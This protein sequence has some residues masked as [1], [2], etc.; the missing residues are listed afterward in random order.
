MPNNLVAALIVKN[1]EPVL[2]RC[3]TSLV[4]DVKRFVINDNGSTD[5]T[6]GILEE[7]DAVQVPGPWIDYA[8][9]RNLVLNV[10]KQWGD[11][12]F[13]GIDAD[14]IFHTPEGWVWPELTADG[15]FIELRL[16]D[17]RYQ[18]L[19]IVKSTSGLA[20][21]GVIHEAIL[22]PPGTV[23]ETLHGPWIEVRNDGARARDPN[24]QMNDLVTLLKA[25]TDHPENGRY[26]FYLAQQ[27]KDMGKYEAAKT[28]YQNRIT[29]GG[30]PPETQYARLMLGVT[31]EWLGENPVLAYLD[32]YEHMRDRA[33]PLYY[34]ADWY[35]RNNMPAMAFVLANSAPVIAPANGLFIAHDVYA[36][37]LPDIIA[38]TAWYAGQR[39]AGLVA[40]RV[41]IQ[42][43]AFPESERARIEANATFYERISK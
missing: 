35:R 13:C 10:A 23:T 40:A 37:K 30:W 42:E 25:V 32:A 27:L 4:L 17:L 20:W 5:G 2:R 14:E 21:G 6:P 22:A 11:Y 41:L 3:L 29:L 15:Y 1:E 36:W 43:Q 12:V 28:W 34:A 7:F 8:A 9:N 16:G 33:E 26:A 19:A 31:M 24:T 18:R 39:T 38:S